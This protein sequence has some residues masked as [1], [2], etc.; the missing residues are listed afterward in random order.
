MPDKNAAAHRVI[1]NAKIL[2]KL[3]FEVVFIGISKNGQ[4]TKTTYLGFDCWTIKYSC[5]RLWDIKT[6]KKIFKTYN[7]AEGIIAYNYP[8]IALWRLMNFCKKNNVKLIADCTEWYGAQGNNLITKMLKGID[9]FLRM[10]FLHPRL[11]GIIVISTF[12]Y[13]YY[14]EKLPTTLIPP[15]VDIKEKKWHYIENTNNNYLRLVYAGSPGKNKDKINV[16]V[17]ALSK[18]KNKTY[19]L[20]IIGISNKE[21]LQYYPEHEMLIRR[22]NN[23]IIFRGRLSHQET[24]NYVHMA[25]FFIF[26]RDKTRVTMAGFPTKFVESISCGT[27]IITNATSDLMNYI[28]VGVN[29]FVLENDLTDDL[30]NIFQLNFDD[31]KRLKKNID[32]TIFDY[33]LYVKKIKDFLEETQ[34]L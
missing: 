7:N 15:L 34:L 5:R 18:I 4:E 8:S 30:N 1:N 11:D 28:N 2:V 13:N 14:K 24:L 9:S 20:E 33:N 12:L 3:G 27:P 19:T 16:V 6:T 32:N 23:Q 21:Y 17:E 26:Y 25:H 22:L 10:N 29:G 31:L